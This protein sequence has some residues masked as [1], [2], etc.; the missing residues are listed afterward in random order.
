M[1]ATL[2]G[3]VEALKN[4]TV[5][6]SM[7]VD[8]C[9]ESFE[10]NNHEL[11]QRLIGAESVISAIYYDVRRIGR[12]SGARLKQFQDLSD[13]YRHLI[14]QIE[15]LGLATRPFQ[16][17]SFFSSA[18][19]KRLTQQWAGRIFLRRTIRYHFVLRKCRMT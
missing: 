13:T 7:A 14:N 5:Q 16:K 18:T 10:L 8:L 9:V 4:N 17:P 1:L 2:R 3:K 6:R 15:R 12:E 11:I 19:K